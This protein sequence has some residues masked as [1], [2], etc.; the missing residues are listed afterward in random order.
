VDKSTN[1]LVLKIAAGAKQIRLPIGEGISGT[2]AKDGVPLNIPDAYADPRFDSGHD[3]QTGYRTSSILC[4]PVKNSE[5]EIIAV[6]QAINKLG[7]GV[8]T[9][10]DE[11]LMDILGKQAGVTLH[12]AKQY[13][14]VMKS[15]QRQNSLLDLIKTLHDDLG[16]ASMLFTLTNRLPQLLGADRTTIFL[17]DNKKN[18]LVSMQG[19]VEI[20]I[21]SD[22]GIAGECFTSAKTIN[23]PDAYEDPRFNQAF[24][25][26]SGYRTRSILAMVIGGS[27]KQPIGCVQIINKEDG[28]AFNE[29][30]EDTLGFFLG[31]AGPILHSSQLLSSMSTQKKDHEV[32]EAIGD[33]KVQ[34]REKHKTDHSADI[35]EEDEEEEDD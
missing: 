27:E 24:D 2:V 15:E 1:E 9:E 21:P 35:I 17:L 18:E 30:D 20:R 12:N 25:K 4:H 11:Y 14:I 6:L 8:F 7:G 29:H 28:E 26:K 22:K 32:S 5:G 10:D 34:K 3:S 19:A 16:V 31:I 23:I 33:L 13:E